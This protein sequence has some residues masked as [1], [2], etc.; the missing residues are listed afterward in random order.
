[1]VDIVHP[2]H[3]ELVTLSKTDSWQTRRSG[4]YDLL[5]NPHPEH[6]PDHATDHSTIDSQPVHPVAIPAM[7]KAIDVLGNPFAHPRRL[8]IDSFSPADPDV[9]SWWN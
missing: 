9:P 4:I 5:Q 3:E 2:L 6:S 8:N 1:M 7:Q